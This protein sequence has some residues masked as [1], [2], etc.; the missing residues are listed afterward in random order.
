MKGL[1]AF[2]DFDMRQPEPNLFG[3]K[4]TEARHF[5]TFSLRQAS[6][7]KSAEIDNEV[8]TLVN[9]MNAMYFIGQN[10][11]GCAKNWWLRQGTSDNHTSQTVI[12]NL[13]TILENQGKDVNTFL[14]WDA[15]HGADQD[16]E[17]FISCIDNVTGFTKRTKAEK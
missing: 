13:A 10:N 15:G 1:P 16:P 14:Y 3:N 4:T 8:K 7:N 2:D 6:V 11:D 9:L 12:V 5:T 17:D